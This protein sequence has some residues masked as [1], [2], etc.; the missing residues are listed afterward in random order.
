MAR[1]EVFLVSVESTASSRI[2]TGLAIASQ[3][4]WLA[5]ADLPGLP[6][7]SPYGLGPGQPMPGQPILLR[8]PIAP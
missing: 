2:T 8:H 6:G 1:T 7:K 4:R 3:G 5:P